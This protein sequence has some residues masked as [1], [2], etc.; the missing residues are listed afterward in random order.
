MRQLPGVVR[1]LTLQE[2]VAPGQSA[3]TNPAKY[4][5]D[6][7]NNYVSLCQA[8][9]ACKATFHDL[10]GEYRRAHDAAASAPQLVQ[11][12]DGNGHVHDVLLDADRVT[13]A[14]ADALNQ[15]ETYPLIAAAIDASVGNPVAAT[16]IAGRVIDA[17]MP[18]LIPD[19]RLGCRDCPSSAPTK[20]TPSIE[21]RARSLDRH[22]RSSAS[23]TTK[24]LQAVCAAW[25]VH[26]IDQIAF[27]DA[28][29][30][31]AHAHRHAHLAAGRRPAMVRHLPAGSAQR[32]RADVLDARRRHPRQGRPAMPR[33]DP[34]CLPRGSDEGDRHP[35]C[36]SQTP[37]I[38]FLA[39]LG[40]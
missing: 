23:S 5:S 27:A 38:H 16:A 8:D 11:G 19:L 17:N 13:Q 32:D 12:D 7:F 36:E 6:A 4:L 34:S 15:R 25:P 29:L 21:H 31:R 35:G 40:G 2:P 20:P 30:D 26:P 24:S 10:S 9:P 18:L 37:P 14:L 1:T 3:Y 28:L 22:F 33:R 39:S